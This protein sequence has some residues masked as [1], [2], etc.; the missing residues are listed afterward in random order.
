MLLVQNFLRKKKNSAGSR[1]YHNRLRNFRKRRKK[2]LFSILKNSS[3][4]KNAFFLWML[5]IFGPA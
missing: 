2:Y 5:H 1:L 3:S 4:K